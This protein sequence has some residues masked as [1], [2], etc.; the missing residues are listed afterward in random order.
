ML[1]PVKPD[2]SGIA[3]QMPLQFHQCLSE[4]CAN[5]TDHRPLG[6][7]VS[8]GSDS[9]GLL[10]G[11][12]RLLPPGKLVALTVDHG[13]RDS[14]ADEARWVKSNCRR[15]GVCHET[16]RWESGQPA[17]GLQAAARAAR[18]RL[19]TAASARLGLAAVLTAHTRNDQDETLAMRRARSSTDNAPGLAGISPAT[20]F[21][22]RMWVLR[23]L[24][25]L[26]RADIRGFLR[27]AGV[28][29][30]DDPSNNDP[31]FERVRV[32]EL[33]KGRLATPA[34]PVGAQIAFA[35]SQQAYKAAKFIDANCHVEPD[36]MVWV[37]RN[38]DDDAN[39]IMAVIEAL[40]DVC[41]GAS[42]SLDRR[43]K[44]T[45]AEF[46]NSGGSAR[47]NR[48]VSLGRTLV[49]C[50]GT[51]LTVSRERRG[52]EKLDLAPGASGVWDGR[53]WIQNLT[54]GS[55]LT[56]SGG[57]DGGV[58]PS[59]NR[60]LAGWASNQSAKDGVV[61]GFI[62]RQLAGRSSHILPIYELPLAQALTRL[63]TTNRFPACPLGNSL[64]IL[65]LTAIKVQ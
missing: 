27:S 33:L 28:D 61:G 57:G 34:D 63:V 14:S 10:Y 1:H 32:R 19:L 7:A 2:I 38:S 60:D 49:K 48:T 47:G 45:L 53:Y 31:R 56:V 11:L 40:I 13:L 43:G 30:V 59:F 17:T 64:D 24:L 65:A 9:L 4:F 12:A 5:L 35:R 8:G 41:G 54:K 44:A 51:Y 15:L 16:L 3:G 55:V 37:R 20:L 42:R 46:L 22:G 36:G 52:I 6:V 62:C 29:W 26:Y 23:P 58:E 18:Y 21:A 39:V 50:Q 25:G